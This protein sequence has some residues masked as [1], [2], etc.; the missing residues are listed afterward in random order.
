M[1]FAVAGA[2]ALLAGLGWRAVASGRAGVWA[3]MGPV[4]GV[5][6]VAALVV[7]GIHV[8]PDMSPAVAVAAG[9]G[10]GLALFAATRAFIRVVRGW[11]AF[12]RQAEDVYGRRGRL[13]L[14]VALAVS[15]GLI[16][17]GEELFWR[18]LVQGRLAEELGRAAG[19]VLAWLAY[20][21]ANAAS[22]SLPLLAAAVVSGA[23]WAALAAWTGGVLAGMVCH[24]AWTGL[25]LVY[26]PVRPPATTAAA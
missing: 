13:S 1:R 15:L 8:S 24:A 22:G 5:L 14:P 23:V 17:T 9:L 25:M 19:A 26:P 2:G 11:G 16:V 10:S 18:G 20:V 6:G 12:R 21:A 7:G 3:V 4:Y